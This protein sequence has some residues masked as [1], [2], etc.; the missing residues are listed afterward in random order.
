MLTRTAQ[1]MPLLLTALI[2]VLAAGCGSDDKGTNTQTDPTV[3]AVTTSTVSDITETTAECGGNVTS[4]GGATVT[5]RGVCRSTDP[6]P[7]IADSKTTDGTGTGGFTSSI[8]GLTANTPYYVRAYATNDVGTGYGVVRSFTTEPPDERD[9]TVTDIDGNVY[10]T[11][12]IGD[13]WWM[14]E[15]L[16]VTRYR[17]GDPIS[18]VTDNSTWG[19]QAAGA[20][21]NYNND[22]NYVST[23]GRLYNWY[24]VADTRNIAPEGWRVP[25]DEDWK[26]LE[27]YLGMSQA[28]T[29]ASSWRGTDEG[30]RLKDTTTLWSS[31]NTGATNETG[32]TALSG[33]YRF[34]GGGFYGISY[35]AGFWSATEES[36]GNA[37]TRYLGNDFSQVSRNS[38][39]KYY[40]YSVRCVRD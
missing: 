13:Q 39:D 9:S 12:K 35:G 16:K 14:V 3:P 32:F 6:T 37:W 10:H 1:A 24:A 21:C 25:T 7:S 40:G 34:R 22:T 5:A 26:Q 15:N 36:S 38:L 30:G 11:V 28:Q 17:N 31:P 8:T 4:D 29:D 18:H 27:T 20:W 2:L 33:G 19:S 23:Y